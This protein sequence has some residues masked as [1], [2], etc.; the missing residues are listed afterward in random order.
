M[1]ITEME[2]LLESKK[3]EKFRLDKETRELKIKLDIKKYP[4][5]IC[6]EC[7]EGFMYDGFGVGYTDL[8]VCSNCN[9]STIRR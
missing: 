6:L 1:E 3:D 8:R 2:K 7:S 5:R 4:N 9:Y